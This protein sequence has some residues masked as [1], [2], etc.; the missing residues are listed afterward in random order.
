MAE[1]IELREQLLAD[2]ADCA[3]ECLLLASGMNG[4]SRTAQ[5]VSAVDHA[6]SLAFSIEKF[7]NRSASGEKGCAVSH[8]LFVEE[9]LAEGPH[10]LR[11]D[12]VDP[13]EVG[14]HGAAIRV[15]ATLR[16]GLPR[17]PMPGRG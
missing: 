2:K 16:A 1:R 13:D 9:T 8:E 12:V 5:S 7:V 6:A 4:R 10:E 3:R 17:A 15:E 11:Q 14:V